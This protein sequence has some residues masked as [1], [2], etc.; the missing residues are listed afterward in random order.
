M[1]A[2][3]SI[4]NVS[5]GDQ[6]Y[7]A[8]VKKVAVYKCS[9]KYYVHY[10]SK[11]WNASWDEWVEHERTAPYTGTNDPTHI[12]LESPPDQIDVNFGASTSTS[13]AGP[14]TSREKLKPKRTTDYG[15]FTKS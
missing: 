14:S 13:V 6:I 10:M 9:P 11:K 3:G 15:P 4:I 5:C 8:K 2:V 7:T 1:I 12:D